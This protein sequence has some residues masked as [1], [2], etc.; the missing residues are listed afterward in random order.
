LE[1]NKNSIEFYLKIGAPSLFFSFSA[2]SVI[3]QLDLKLKLKAADSIQNRM[4][5]YPLRSWQV[6][7][8]NGMM[9]M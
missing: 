7:A 6:I 5:S 3:A 9:K 4:H 2:F 8:K 1:Y